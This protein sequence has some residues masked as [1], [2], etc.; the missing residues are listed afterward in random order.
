MCIEA[1]ESTTN[2]RSSGLIVY[3]AQRNQTSEGEKNVTLYRPSLLFK[4]IVGQVSRNSAI[5]SFF[6]C[7]GE[8]LVSRL[9]L[10]GEMQRGSYLLT[11]VKLKGSRNCLR[12]MKNE[13]EDAGDEEVKEVVENAHIMHAWR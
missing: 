6:P 11:S 2:S 4:K 10:L 12:I 9:H 1:L 13:E 5:P 7:A 8:G 3:G